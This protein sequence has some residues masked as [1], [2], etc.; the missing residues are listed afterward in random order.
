MSEK[1]GGLASIDVKTSLTDD[2]KNRQFQDKELVKLKTKVVF[3][4]TLD[5]NLDANCLLRFRERIYAHREG[6]SIKNVLEKSH[7]L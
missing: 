4:E 5:A 1:G 2:N 3:R 7:G 6:D